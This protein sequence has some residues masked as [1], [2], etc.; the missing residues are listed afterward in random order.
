MV[1]E[2]KLVYAL[3]LSIHEWLLKHLLCTITLVQ[4]NWLNLGTFDG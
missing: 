3:T 4:V 1:P 2:A